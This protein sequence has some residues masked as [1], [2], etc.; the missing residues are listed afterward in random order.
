MQCNRQGLLVR[1]KRLDSGHCL[2]MF[3]YGYLSVVSNQCAHSDLSSASISP[4]T[5]RGRRDA[6]ADHQFVKLSKPT[7]MLPN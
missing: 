5:Q 7:T 4:E 1:T 3:S 6:P 2:E